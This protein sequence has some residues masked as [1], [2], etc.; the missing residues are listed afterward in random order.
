M[1]KEKSDVL[2]RYAG[3]KIRNYT[4]EKM[5]ENGTLEKFMLDNSEKELEEEGYGIINVLKRDYSQ[6][7]EHMEI[8][9]TLEVQKRSYEE[10]VKERKE[11]VEK[12]KM[13]KQ[14]C[15]EAIID[16]IIEKMQEEGKGQLTAI[17][18]TRLLEE[19]VHDI[20]TKALLLAVKNIM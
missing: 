18:V 1:E 8:T 14:E 5:K 12:H 3:A 13:K 15:K 19:L 7:E 11:R 2:I 20:E 17:Y 6:K 9:Y 4:F 10:L 16:L